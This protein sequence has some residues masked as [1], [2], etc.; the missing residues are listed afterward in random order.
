[1]W[2][3]ELVVFAFVFGAG[4]AFGYDAVDEKFKNYVRE[5][6]EEHYLTD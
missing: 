2:V 1:M 4:Y 6:K 5:S 3:I